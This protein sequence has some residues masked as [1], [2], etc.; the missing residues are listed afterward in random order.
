MSGSLLKAAR[1][2]RKRSNSPVNNPQPTVPIKV[3]AASAAGSVLTVTFDQPVILDGVPQYA[4]DVVGAAATSAVSR[5]AAGWGWWV[6]D[7]AGATSRAAVNV[8]GGAAGS[9]VGDRL[10]PPG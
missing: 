5:S 7:T 2:A 10:A 9:V 8:P 4:T 1:R 3:T 6:G